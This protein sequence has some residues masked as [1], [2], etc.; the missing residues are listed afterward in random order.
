MSEGSPRR[1]RPWWVRTI[2]WGLP[3]RASAWASAWLCLVLAGVSVAY[4]VI[5]ADRRFLLGGIMLLGTIGYG[6]SIGWVD[7]HGSWS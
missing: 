3:T 4:A 7:R 6:L 1:P 5:T 2:L